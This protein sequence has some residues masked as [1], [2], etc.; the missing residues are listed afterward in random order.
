MTKATLNAYALANQDL[1]VAHV[2]ATEAD[3]LE[4]K[5]PEVEINESER[6]CTTLVSS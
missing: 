4:L 1:V 2:G 3:V 6:E 5:A